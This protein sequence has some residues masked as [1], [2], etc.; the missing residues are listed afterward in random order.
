[1]PSYGTK[2]VTDPLV[3]RYILSLALRNITPSLEWSF[4]MEETIGKLGWDVRNYSGI[5]GLRPKCNQV[6][7]LQAWIPC[8]HMSG[9]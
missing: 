1:M 6:T 7:D 9:L 8:L 2:S 3:L 4:I 5:R